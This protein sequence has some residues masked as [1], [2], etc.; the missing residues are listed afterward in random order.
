MISRE[1][2][3][4]I[5]HIIHLI[6]VMPFMK[7][8]VK[9]SSGV[10]LTGKLWRKEHPFFKDLPF[11]TNIPRTDD[12]AESL[13]SALC[14]G[15]GGGFYNEL[16]IV[17]WLSFISLIILQPYLMVFIAIWKRFRWDKSFLR[18]DGSHSN[19]ARSQWYTFTAFGGSGN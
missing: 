19:F 12:L 6:P 8:R 18:N 9:H 7:N 4:F 16:L 17:R 13:R 2:C 5:I 3:W 1:H 15:H 11:Y 10:D 14:E